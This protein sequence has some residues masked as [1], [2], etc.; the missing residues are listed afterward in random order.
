MSAPH[1]PRPPIAG[2]ECQSCECR[3]AAVRITLRTVPGGKLIESTDLCRECATHSV[4][5]ELDGQPRSL[6]LG[7]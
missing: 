3:P 7:A 6:R 1:S 4:V 5:F 2:D